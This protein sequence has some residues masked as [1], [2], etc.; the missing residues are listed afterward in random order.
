M[1]IFR[2]EQAAP[3]LSPAVFA[4]Q[5]QVNRAGLLFHDELLPPKTG[6]IIDGQCH[7]ESQCCSQIQKRHILQDRKEPVHFIEARELF[8]IH[9]CD[10]M[11]WKG[12]LAKRLCFYL[13]LLVAE[14]IKILQR[15][16]NGEC[17][18]LPPDLSSIFPIRK[19]V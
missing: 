12:N 8:W 17:I 16:K 3:G 2:D 6:K 7:A 5:I 9:F 10:R 19:L 13:F 15:V 18:L 4:Y 11:H 14:K 1:K